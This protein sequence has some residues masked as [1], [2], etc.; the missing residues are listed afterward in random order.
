MKFRKKIFQKKRR[1]DKHSKNDISLKKKD[2]RE[3]NDLA[4]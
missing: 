1:E 4:I 2:F 3:K